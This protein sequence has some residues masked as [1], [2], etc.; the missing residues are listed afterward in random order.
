MSRTY[1]YARVSSSDQSLQR[2]LD[3]LT[4]YGLTDRDIIT[5]KASGKSFNRAGYKTLKEQMLHKGDILVIKELDRL[6]RD[7][8][9]V[10]EEWHDIQAMGV[11]IVVLDTPILNT[12]DKSDLEKTLISNIVFELLSYL[13]DKTR[14]KIKASQAEGIR[15]AKNKNVKFGRPV[16][17]KPP[18]FDAEVTK[19]RNGEQ[20]AVATYKKLGMSKTTFY[21]LVKK[22][23]EV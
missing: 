1:G 10:K 13:A 21:K 5:D 4:A 3:A 23:L 20:S 12:A 9:G 19:W 8:D 15:A 17:I 11:D 22:E 18:N 6:S 7:Y 2:Q 16:A 14:R